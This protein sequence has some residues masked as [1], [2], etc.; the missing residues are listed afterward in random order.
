MWCHAS[1]VRG[2]KQTQKFEA[3]GELPRMAVWRRYVFCCDVLSGPCLSWRWVSCTLASAPRHQ[4]RG[5]MPPLG[6][7]RAIAQ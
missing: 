1:C 6:R 2:H 3:L 7:S 4:Q 5:R